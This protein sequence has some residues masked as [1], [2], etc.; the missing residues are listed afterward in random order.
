[1]KLEH[2]ALN[3]ADPVAMAAWY[4]KYLQLKIVFKITAAPYTHFLADDEG[5]MMLEIY[6]N[7][8]D[9]VP[10]YAD[11]HPL[12]LHVAFVSTDPAADKSRLIAAG[13]RL[14]ADHKEIGRAHV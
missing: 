8:P 12:L 1:M 3:V 4:E 6:N 14:L 7:P 5:R 9:K 13:A 10:P 2:V 11:M